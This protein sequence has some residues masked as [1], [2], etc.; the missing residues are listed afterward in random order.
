MT[1]RTLTITPHP[2]LVG[3]LPLGDIGKTLVG[4]GSPIV[5]DEGDDLERAANSRSLRDLAVDAA[6]PSGFGSISLNDGGDIP[7]LVASARLDALTRFE[8]DWIVVVSSDL[9]GTTFQGIH[10]TTPVT[11]GGNV[12]VATGP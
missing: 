2:S 3:N 9:S 10:G 12:V 4:G 6:F 5:L 7:P 1:F 11:A 8:E